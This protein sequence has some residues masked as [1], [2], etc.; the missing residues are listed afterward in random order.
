VKRRTSRRGLPR[1]LSII[2]LLAV[3]A[4]LPPLVTAI[5]SSSRS[6]AS[7]EGATPDCGDDPYLPSLDELRSY[8]LSTGISAEDEHCAEMANVREDERDPSEKRVS[9][10]G[11]TSGP[12][13]VLVHIALQAPACAVESMRWI[14]PAACGALFLYSFP[15]DSIS[16]DVIGRYPDKRISGPAGDNA[17][18]HFAW[19][20]LITAHF[21][22]Q[23]WS[24]ERAKDK[25]RT[26]TDLHETLALQ[27]NGTPQECV[28]D[29]EADRANNDL[30]LAF[31]AT[32]RHL[33]HAGRVRAITAK[34]IEYLD[35]GTGLDLRGG[36]PSRHISIRQGC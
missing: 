8:G 32:I 24:V 25:A 36:C 22:S 5:A 6:L 14:D 35:S 30:G 1:P 7:A 17:V 21:T 19:L 18:R 31:G 29:A 26:L 2:V 27:C 15:A 13:G 34:A 33:N 12:V 16:R 9:Q 11:V 20:A 4:G 23:D 10:S 28:W 3:F